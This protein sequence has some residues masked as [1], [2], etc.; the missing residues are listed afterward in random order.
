MT[1]TNHLFWTNG[2]LYEGCCAS[3]EMGVCGRVD[4][5]D[6]NTNKEAEVK[7]QCSIALKLFQVSR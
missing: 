1:E 2:L 3:G 5:D 7:I 4:G 6:M